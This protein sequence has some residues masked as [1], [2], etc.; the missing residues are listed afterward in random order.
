MWE[1][2]TKYSATI[3]ALLLVFSVVTLHM[4]M[5]REALLGPLSPLA[6]SVF[7]SDLVFDF[8]WCA[9]LS[10]LMARSAFLGFALSRSIV[11]VSLAKTTTGRPSRQRRFL[12]L[13]SRIFSKADLIFEP[14][15]ALCAFFALYHGGQ[16]YGY[17]F[18]LFIILAIAIFALVAVLSD[19]AR[20][21]SLS[22]AILDAKAG[23]TGSISSTVSS[24]VLLVLLLSITSASLR[25]GEMS[26]RN[27]VAV[28]ISERDYT[29]CV[30]I[31][32]K[33]AEGVFLE[34]VF[35][36]SD[37]RERRFFVPF[38][39]IDSTVS[40]GGSEFFWDRQL[41]TIACGAG[42]IFW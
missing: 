35:T 24:L 4:L 27:I 26:G 16:L 12:Q 22:G 23:S 8:V 40:I 25:A 10:A 37:D 33:S 34:R 7:Y 30:S 11:Y 6:D 28:Q 2:V 19:Q 15:A 20:T 41:E 13:T 31:L 18:L 3:R 17:D 36:E 32:G 14:F 9:I 42:D 38:G 21:T 5:L 1:L 29:E 39:R